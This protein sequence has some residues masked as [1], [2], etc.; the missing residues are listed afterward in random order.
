[1]ENYINNKNIWITGASSGIGFEIV[2]E[3]AQFH[4]N[5]ILSARNFDKITQKIASLFTEKNNANFFAFPLDLRDEESIEDSFVSIYS[6]VGYPDVLI[7]NAGVFKANSFLKTSYEEFKSMVD[8]NLCGAFVATKCVLPKMIEKKDG[9]IINISSVTAEKT[10]PYCAAYSASKSGLLAMMRSLREEVRQ[11]GIKVVNISPGA[12]A[13]EL[14]GNKLD[15]NREKMSMP[16]DIAKLVMY[17][18]EMSRLSPQSM[19]EEITIR[20]QLGD[21]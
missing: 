13:T 17:V 21:L 19:I 18:L 4:T 9:L 5:L 3:L 2:R 20:P 7:N 12:T 15:E 10:F 14:W 8:T 16:N 11:Y 1:M 6:E